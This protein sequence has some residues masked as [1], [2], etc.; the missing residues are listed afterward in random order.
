MYNTL[1]ILMY[2]YTQT[3]APVLLFLGVTPGRRHDQYATRAISVTIS[4]A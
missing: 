2:Q 1:R 3:E 4:R